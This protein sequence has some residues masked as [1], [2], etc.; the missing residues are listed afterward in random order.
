M[1][2]RHGP[3]RQEGMSLLIVLLLLLVMTIIGIASLRGTL[4][5]ERMSANSAD[6]ARAFQASE[7]I[8]REAES[9]AEG[10]PVLPNA[11]CVA[12]ICA[13]AV[14][15]AAP[16]WKANGFWNDG[17]TG[18]LVSPTR[19][20][21]VTSRYVVEF[22]GKATEVSDDCTTSGSVSPEDACETESSRYRIT[23]N[24]RSPSGAEVILQS[25]YAVP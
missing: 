12:G 23:V 25:T 19:V 4:L 22:M 8:L 24:S 3:S 18:Y 2:Y 10:K 20:D 9:V 1:N 21:G 17:G 15:G 5:Q 13:R 7:A 11:G 16:A 6:R 14:G